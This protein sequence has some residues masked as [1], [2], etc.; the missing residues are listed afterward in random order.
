MPWSVEVL[1]GAISGNFERALYSGYAV[2]FEGQQRSTGVPAPGSTLWY[3]LTPSA[4]S[5]P[6][7]VV[8]LPEYHQAAE[9]SVRMCWSLRPPT[10]APVQSLGEMCRGLRQVKSMCAARE[11]ASMLANLMNRVK[12][13]IH[14]GVQMLRN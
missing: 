2:V 11:E 8:I 14:V 9:L 10:V 6:L 5:L 12:Q 7:F 4:W 3:L 13:A 1:V